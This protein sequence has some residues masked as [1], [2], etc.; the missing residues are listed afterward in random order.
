[1][2]CM[3]GHDSPQHILA[4]GTIYD[5]RTMFHSIIRLYLLDVNS[6]PN[7]YAT[8][9]GLHVVCTLH[10][11][12]TRTRTHYDIIFFFELS[13]SECVGCNTHRAQHT[14]QIIYHILY[15]TT[16]SL[17]FPDFFFEIIFFFFRLFGNSAKK[18]S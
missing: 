3:S 9:L 11:A 2:S 6:L 15:C 7:T 5:T 12:Y 13:S 8:V 10:S 4:S 17:P 1:M 16:F 18:M 14:T